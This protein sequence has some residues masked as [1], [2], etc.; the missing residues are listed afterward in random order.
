MKGKL[1]FA[2]STAC[3]A[4]F[5]FFGCEKEKGSSVDA[6]G[7]GGAS[8]VPDDGYVVAQVDGTPL[9]WGEME[10]RANGFLQDDINVNHLMIP[11]GKMEEA[12]TFFR[13]KAV[14]T[15]VFKT[16]MMNEALR[17]K[18][19]LSPLDERESYQN[20]A[21]TLEKRH[22]TTNDFFNKGPLDPAT[23]RREF[24]D[25]M[26]IDKLLK[27]VV[28]PTLKVVDEEIRV[29]SA[30][31]QQTNDLIRAR[32]ENVRQ[33]LLKGADFEQT[34]RAVSECPSS[35]KGG[36]IGEFAR[37]GRLP[38]EVEEQ[39]F[40]QDIGEIGPVVR[41]SLGYHILKVTAKMP[42]RAKTD[43]TPEVP[44]SIRLS[45]IL[46]R[47]I[48]INR[49]A[50]SDVILKLKYDQGVNEFYQKLLSTA[51]VECFLYPDMTFGN[52]PGK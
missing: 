46:F 39:A 51:S 32:L 40:R 1:P 44:E 29:H 42:K 26:V 4:V 9:T 13:R 30:Q 12:K 2:L 7:K 37:G 23:M 11:K 17:R 5:C 34:A 33:Q 14:N 15:F 19:K 43:T 45:H 10:K 38:K 21:R 18:I 41:S 48:P 20:L 36:D 25:G 31:L 27:V 49:K 22:W 47:S 24:Q 16:V 28:R 3:L 50:I 35:K 6:P 52:E 8:A